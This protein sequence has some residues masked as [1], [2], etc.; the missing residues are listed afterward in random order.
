MIS[1]IYGPTTSF[2][3]RSFWDSIHLEANHFPRPWMLIGDFNGILY[4]SNRSSNRGIDGGSR[5]MRE[6]LDNLG[7]ISIPSSGSHY[8]WSNCRHGRS[9][10]NSRINR[11]MAN[12]DWWNRFP[13]ASIQ[14]LPQATSDHF[15]QVL[16][17]FGQNSYVKRLFRFEAAWV[18]D[19]RNYWVVNHAWHS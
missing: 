15:P 11:G 2:T 4:S 16:R 6:A 5:F 10:I 7:M 12:E 9:Q 14:L 3:K 13:N 1:A 8:T 19:P 18:E 17:C